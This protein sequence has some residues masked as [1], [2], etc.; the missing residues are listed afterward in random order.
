M[1]MK[2]IAWLGGLLEGEGCFIFSR[3][4]HPSIRLKMTD[5]DTIVKVADI[6][7]ARIYHYG[8]AWTVVANGAYA[9]GWM[10]TLYPFLNRNRQNRIIKIVWYWK[11]NST[12]T[13]I[14][15]WERATCHPNKPIH[16]LGL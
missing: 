1:K 7:D 6:W 2:D 8:N 12:R 5:R 14:R 10:M 13:L 3:K 9:I 4:W 11:D 16:A 15:H